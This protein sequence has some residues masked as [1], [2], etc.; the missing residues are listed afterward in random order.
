MKKAIRNKMKLLGR[1]SIFI[2][3]CFFYSACD[4]INPEEQIPAFLEINDFEFTVTPE[5][6]ANSAQITDAWVFVNDISL[7]VYELPA[8]IPV[9]ELGNQ[10]ITIFPVIRENGVR[11]LPI[12]Y[13]LYQRYETT[14]ELTPET[15]ISINPTTSFV[16]NA[17]FDLIEDFNTSNHRLQGENPDA[18]ITQDGIGNV[19]FQG[20]EM[21]TFTSSEI[22]TELPTSGGI[23]TFLEFDYKT[24]VIMEICLL[25]TSPSPRDRTRS[26][27][28]SS[29]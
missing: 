18:V 26:R 11:S 10:G 4:I 5:Q 6:G 22:F 28:P 3:F 16:N 19:Q 29:A 20:N 24:N 13:P 21:I 14:I 9:L 17:I 12:I 2:N 23:P 7:G 8:T 15:T 27:M 25:Y 1:W